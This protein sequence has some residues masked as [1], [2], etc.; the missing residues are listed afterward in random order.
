MRLSLLPLARSPASSPMFACVPSL[1]LFGA[2]AAVL[3]VRCRAN[4]VSCVKFLFFEM[5]VVLATRAAL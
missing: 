3:Y 4:L 1:Y 2:C 5:R